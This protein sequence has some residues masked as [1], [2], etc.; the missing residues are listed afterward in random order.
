MP[1]HDVSAT[2]L[3]PWLVEPHGTGAHVWLRRN[4]A[5]FE[6][7]LGDGATQTMWEA[8]FVEGDL[9]RVP[10]DAEVEE[11]FDALWE[12]FEQAGMTD[13]ELLARAMEAAERAQAQADFTALMT[14]TEV[15]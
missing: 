8:D 1:K 13:R 10:T 5:T 2:E 4:I 11:D 14:D 12:A 7:D 6:Q 15:M 9:S 3:A